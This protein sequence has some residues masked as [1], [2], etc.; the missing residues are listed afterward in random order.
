MRFLHNTTR[1]LHNTHS[2][3]HNAKSS[4][5][6]QMWFPEKRPS[7]ST[8]SFFNEIRLTASEIS[9]RDVKYASRVKYLLRK[10]DGEFYF[11]FCFSR[12]FH[13]PSGL[14]HIFATQKYFIKKLKQTRQI[15]FIAQY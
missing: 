10:C 13:N 2:I 4:Y 11:T 12:K 1:F 14:F 5:Q 6:N 3:L 8:W 9:L 7:Q 15:D